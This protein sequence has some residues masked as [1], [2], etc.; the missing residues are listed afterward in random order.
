M[1][2]NENRPRMPPVFKAVEYFGQL[3]SILVIEL[4]QWATPSAT[5]SETRVLAIVGTRD[6][7]TETCLDIPY[8]AQSGRVSVRA[9]DITTL[10]CLVGRINDGRR[11]AIV[12][13]SGDMARAEFFD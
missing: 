6:T 4:P 2:I 10:M 8:Y 11:C 3:L 13:R 7:K 5:R 12:D 9:V 1:D